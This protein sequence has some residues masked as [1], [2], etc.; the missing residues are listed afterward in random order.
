M[1][2]ITSRFERRSNLKNPA[3]WLVNLIRSGGGS[4]TAAGVNVTPQNSLQSTAVFAC[5]RILAEGEAALPLIFYQ[6]L[7]GG[8][9]TRATA[10]RLYPILHDLPNPEMTSI[11]LRETLMGHLALRGNAF[12]EIERDQGNRIKGLWPLRP[13]K[14]EVKRVNGQLVYVVDVP[15]EGPQGLPARNVMHLRGFGYDGL[16]GYSPIALARQAIGLAMATEEFGARF[17]GNG[18]KPG[19]VLETPNKLS[20]KAYD[21]LT[22]WWNDRHQ[23]LENSHRMAI[24]EEGLELHE[25]GIA[26]DEAQFLETRKFQVSEIARM[27]RVPPH[28]LA[29]LEGGASYASIEQMSLEFVIYTLTPWLVRWEQAIYR[30]LLTEAERLSYFAEHLIDGLLRGDIQSRY[31]AYNIGRTGGWLSADDIRE[32]ENMNP[33]PDGEGKIYLVPLNMVPVSQVA[34]PPAGAE[35]Q[36]SRGAGEQGNRALRYANATQDAVEQRARNV[37]KGRRRLAASYERLF[38]DVATRVIRR[39]VADVKRAARKHLGKRSNQDFMAWLKEFYQEHEAFWRRQML[40]VLLNYAEQ[41]GVAVGEELGQE[42]GDIQRFIEEYVEAM[43]G[44][45]CDSSFKQLRALLEEALIDESDPAEAIESRLNE[46]DEH[47]GQRMARNEANRA[48]NALA[49]AFY[50]AGGVQVMRWVTIGDSCPYCKALDGRVVGI[51]S[52]FLGKDD[53]F[54]PDGAERPLSKRNDIKHGPLHDECDCQ[55]VAG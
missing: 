54:Q 8:G 9:K 50:L 37:A 28:M 38:A 1:G 52:N 31:E 47:R 48:G 44:R 7:N 33:L 36:G 43:A 19:G 23:G 29:Y 27:F 13:D 40:P 5:A 6:R 14:T 55:V 41:V 34:E 42:P 26:P 53:D 2:L 3:D 49:W 21:R 24:L 4:A 11:E 30:D 15:G 35:E 51:R 46:W 45:E 25:I 12:A 22:K 20:D 10:H 39:E 16:M 17:F 32:L 18:A